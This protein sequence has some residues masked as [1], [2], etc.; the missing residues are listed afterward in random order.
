MRRLA[1]LLGTPVRLLLIGAIHVYRATFSHALGGQCRFHP[2]CSR[3]ALDAVRIHG[4]LKG[5]ALAAWRVLRCSPLTAGG[6]DPV[7]SRA[8]DVRQRHTPEA[9]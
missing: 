9:A 6:I 2:S 3:Y 1:W 4:A 8:G 7:P 5:S